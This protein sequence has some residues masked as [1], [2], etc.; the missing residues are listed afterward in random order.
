MK[1]NVTELKRNLH[2]IIDSLATE[3]IIIRNGG[4]VAQIAPILKKYEDYPKPEYCG[5]SCSVQ[6]KG[7]PDIELNFFHQFCT[8]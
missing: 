2:S 3:V 8:W 4:P 1:I 5:A 6:F 7:L